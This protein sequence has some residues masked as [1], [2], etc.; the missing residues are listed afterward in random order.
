MVFI[1]PI[2]FVLLNCAVF[3][4]VL[5]YGEAKDT[6]HFVFLAKQLA[7]YTYILS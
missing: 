6:F 5:L 4:Y 3:C 2:V 7:V 1:D